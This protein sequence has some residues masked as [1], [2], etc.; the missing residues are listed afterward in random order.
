M[1]QAYL[2]QYKGKQIMKQDKLKAVVPLDK[3]R[4]WLDFNEFCAV[5]EKDGAPIYIFSQGDVVNDS[6]GKDVTLYE[7]MEV[8]VFDNDFNETGKPD[9]ILA[10]GILIKNIYS[11]VNPLVKWL[12]RLT[13]NKVDYKSGNEYGYWMSDL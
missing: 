1:A 9:A 5:D 7:G 11:H 4:I 8:S 2:Y 3:T 6:D 13:R 10:E 12:I